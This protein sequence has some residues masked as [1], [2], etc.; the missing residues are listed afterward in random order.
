MP[1]V[2]CAETEC[3]YYRDNRCTAKEINISAGHIH[4]KH[5]GYIHHWECRTFKMSEEAKELFGMLKAYFDSYGERK[6]GDSDE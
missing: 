1:K 3:E 4:T 2:W 5:Q 6:D